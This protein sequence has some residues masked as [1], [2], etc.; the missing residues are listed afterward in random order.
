[1]LQNRAAAG[2]P[3]HCHCLGRGQAV[4]PPPSQAEVWGGLVPGQ[5]SPLPLY[6]H[7]RVL[8]CCRSQGL[9]SALPALA[10]SLDPHPASPSSVHLGLSLAQTPHHRWLQDLKRSPPPLPGELL[11]IP[12]LPIPIAPPV[13]PH[14]SPSALPSP[15]LA[16]PSP[17]P[18]L[19]PLPPPKA[20]SHEPRPVHGANEGL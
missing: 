7:S 5:G 1:M 17:G 2:T 14:P 4:A 8:S 9:L 16:P 15:P 11:G 19:S 6:P 3:E 12:Q 18:P 20:G 13:R 10:H